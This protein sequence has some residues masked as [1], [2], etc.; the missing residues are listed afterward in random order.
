MSQKK[1]KIPNL[2]VKKK[3]KKKMLNN[4]VRHQAEG[5]NRPPGTVERD[6][7]PPEQP[8][9]F[10]R[11]EKGVSVSSSVASVE[12]GTR[13][14]NRNSL[15]SDPMILEKAT[16]V[17]SSPNRAE[18][19][20]SGTQTSQKS[21]GAQ[22]SYAAAA[23]GASRG[24]V[25]QSVDGVAAVPKNPKK[26]SR[27]EYYDAIIPKDTD[28]EQIDFSSNLDPYHASLESPFPQGE[29]ATPEEK[30][31]RE[32]SNRAFLLNE[33]RNGDKRGKESNGRKKR[34]QD[35]YAL[36]PEDAF[37]HTL[38]LY[39]VSE[40]SHKMMV[41]NDFFMEETLMEKTIK[42]KALE[43]SNEKQEALTAT[44]DR[45]DFH[46]EEVTDR[47][48][49]HQISRNHIDQADDLTELFPQCVDEM[50]TAAALFA[51]TKVRVI[52]NVAHFPNIKS[53]GWIEELVHSHGSIHRAVRNIQP[54]EIIQR[55]ETM[56]EEIRFRSTGGFFSLTRMPISQG[57]F[58]QV[59]VIYNTNTRLP[60][61]RFEQWFLLHCD[62][63]RSWKEYDSKKKEKKYAIAIIDVGLNRLPPRLPNKVA[64]Q[65]SEDPTKDPLASYYHQLMALP[66]DPDAEIDRAQTVGKALEKILAKE[67]QVREAIAKLGPNEEYPT[68]CQ[69]EVLIDHCDKPYCRKCRHLDHITKTCHLRPCDLCHQGKHK[70]A[71]CPQKCKCGASGDHL[72]ST[73][74]R[75]F[76]QNQTANKSPVK[77]NSNK[78]KQSPQRRKQAPIV[79]AE[80]FQQV[81]RTRKQ[82]PHAQEG[83][84]QKVPPTTNG[85][86]V[87]ED[88]SPSNTPI[89]SAHAPV[90]NQETL[91]SQDASHNRSKNSNSQ[92]TESTSVQSEAD[93]QT[94]DTPSYESTSSDEDS[95]ISMDQSEPELPQTQSTG[96]GTQ[97]TIVDSTPEQNPANCPQQ[98]NT[99][100]IPEQNS[101]NAPEESNP[102]MSTHS[103]DTMS[104]IGSILK[105]GEP[106]RENAQPVS[107]PSLG[108]TLE[109]VVPRPKSTA[110]NENAAE[111]LQNPPKQ[112]DSPNPFLDAPKE[113]A[114]HIQH[115]ED[116]TTTDVDEPQAS[117][118]LPRRARSNPTTPELRLHKR[119]LWTPLG[120]GTPQ[121]G[122][123]TKAAQRLAK[124]STPALKPTER[125]GR[126]ASRSVLPTRRSERLAKF[127]RN[128][129]RPPEETQLTVSLTTQL[130]IQPFLESDDSTMREIIDNLGKEYRQDNLQARNQ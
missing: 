73:C 90:V 45:I 53:Q 120:Y 50:K 2:S 70:A 129:H 55:M 39:P 75:R 19:P 28:K 36:T 5:A 108:P 99:D 26:I 106:F 69:M 31:A 92:P 112:T 11:P 37:W 96:Q 81:G 4:I 13:Q 72:T 3:K 38:N 126:T 91:A 22:L 15:L 56:L 114:S 67:Q 93:L 41:S 103:A 118:R 10:D 23:A 88:S 52:G 80:G 25:S 86:G 6:S 27:K 20:S 130:P 128:M 100:S 113:A 117:P 84:A 14:E 124:A 78:G 33:V 116:N 95:S 105:L 65:L 64:R 77:S 122:L 66:L 74:P 98:D 61:K 18:G 60:E 62:T 76:Y 42:E 89:P 7:R 109:V 9:E 127:K 121:Y 49:N 87:L 115:Q 57:T 59:K 123:P 102:S 40:K 79:D 35:T 83:G 58:V 17:A 48:D 30:E 24:V 44:M 47:A 68:E 97:A 16:K 34:V 46:L 104:T 107:S 21:S 111:D 71:D 54:E 85:F 51:L 8:I 110:A 29:E 101:V 43:A 32:E 94:K 1:L 125:P 12:G 63:L 119:A 82:T